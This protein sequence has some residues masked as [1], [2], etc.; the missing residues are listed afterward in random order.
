MSGSKPV[1]IWV[2]IAARIALCLC[3]IP[4]VGVALIYWRQGVLTNGPWMEGFITAW[5]ALPLLL[6]LAFQGRI[7]WR[8]P[9]SPELKKFKSVF[10]ILYAVGFCA[11]LYRHD[12]LE[13]Y[14]LATLLALVFVYAVLS[15]YFASVKTKRENIAKFKARHGIPSESP[16]KVDET[17]K[18]GFFRVS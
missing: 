3:A 12:S 15:I 14:V 17:L 2:R 4:V 6:G 13:A 16:H 7:Y 18:E 1:A 5:G 11:L 9:Q 8:Q 10:G